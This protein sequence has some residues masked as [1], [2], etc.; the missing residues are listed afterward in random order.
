M[1]DFE[2]QLRA[3]KEYGEGSLSTEDSKARTYVDANDGVVYEWDAD[4]GGWFPKVNTMSGVVG[5]VGP[6]EIYCYI[7]PE[8]LEIYMSHYSCRV[9]KPWELVTLIML[10][11]VSAS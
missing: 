8:H 7:S 1:D 4:R 10:Q 6:R 3:E 9:R 11:N 2:Y 5:R